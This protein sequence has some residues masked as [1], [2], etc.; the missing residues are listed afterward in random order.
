MATSYRVTVAPTGEVF[1]VAE[2]ERV[3]AA[4]RRSGV[5]L[6]FECGWGSCGTCKVTLLEGS[7]ELLFA[8]SPCV[9]PRDGRRNR[10]VICQSTAASDMVIRA[11]WVE[12]S[13]RP[14]RPTADL[15]ARLVDRE[16]LGP[17]LG[18]F[19]FE[20]ESRTNY[21]EGQ[22]AILDLGD[23][24]R[25][26]Y[27]MS[28]PSGSTRLQ[29]IARRSPGGPGSERLFALP[30]GAGVSLELPYG[31]MWLR[32]TERPVFLVAGG[33]GISA[34][35]GLARRLAEQNDARPVR[36]FY[37]ARSVAELVCWQELSALVTG[38]PDGHLHGAVM[39]PEPAWDG[40]VSL[41][42]DLIVTSADGLADAEIYLA[43]PPPMVDAVL[44]LLRNH[45]VRV[46]RIHYD[47]F[48]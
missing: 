48:G 10:T 38:L 33:T 27:S 18:R 23:G 28:G 4:A 19:T 25:R 26:C 37:G 40:S 30:M 36:A 11:N 43:G 35:L 47:R 12:G 15:E 14:E 39:T 22:Y 1:H 7:A 46:D 20:T 44:A 21:R 32:E 8:D 24:V 2:G 13:P 42:T 31:D 9:T 6:P 16:V 17:E 29:F 41:V 34:I 5:W 3:L 45:S